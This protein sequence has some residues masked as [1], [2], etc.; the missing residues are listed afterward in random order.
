MNRIVKETLAEE[1]TKDLKGDEGGEEVSH[2]RGYQANDQNR[3][4][5]SEE[6]S[7]PVRQG[8]IVSSV[9]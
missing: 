2:E 7:C 4:K 6:R 5:G 9:R 8:S 1:V 3:L